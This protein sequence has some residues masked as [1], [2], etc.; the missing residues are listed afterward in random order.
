MPSYVSEFSIDTSELR[1]LARSLRKVSPEVGKVLREELRAT[2][3]L[4]AVEARA[5]ASGVS[6]GVAATIRTRLSNTQVSVVAGIGERA[7]HVGQARAFEHMG[8]PGTFRHPVYG[9]RNAWVDQSAHP[10]LG[11]A[12]AHKAD[13]VVPRLMSSLDRVF[14]AL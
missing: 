11:P 2:G 13:E 5:I 14:G 9:N 1:G 3:E 7:G 12:F 6:S 4:V 8:L 10:F